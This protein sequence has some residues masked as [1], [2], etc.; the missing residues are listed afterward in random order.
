MYIRFNTVHTHA[1]EKQIIWVGPFSISCPVK[2][3]YVTK[4]AVYHLARV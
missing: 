1:S 4:H 2:K 3:L